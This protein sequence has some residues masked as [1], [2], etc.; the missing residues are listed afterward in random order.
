VDRSASGAPEVRASRIPTNAFDDAIIRH[1]DRHLAE[2]AEVMAAYRELATS[3]DPPVQYVAQLILE[4]EERHHRLLT[5]LVNQ[6]RS[7]TTLTESGPQV[8]WRTRPTDRDGL[9]RAVRRLRRFERR[10]LRQLRRL[11]RGLRPI[12]NHSLDNVVVATLIVD[13]R[14][15]LRLL[16]ELQRLARRR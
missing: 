10:D 12:R 11:S 3:S 2:E 8:P 1:L 15:H 4:D 6:F 13:T 7:S 9:A 16:R 5:E 14:K